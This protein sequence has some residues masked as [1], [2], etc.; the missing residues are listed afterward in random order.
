LSVLRSKFV[1]CWLFTIRILYYLSAGHH[2]GREAISHQVQRHCILGVGAYRGVGW[3]LEG[4]S[5]LRE[6]RLLHSIVMMFEAL[7]V[8]CRVIFYSEVCSTVPVFF[9]RVGDGGWPRGRDEP[10]PEL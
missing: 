3:N 10:V 2:L 9:L 1:N 7:V 8:S 6:L 5:T 4:N